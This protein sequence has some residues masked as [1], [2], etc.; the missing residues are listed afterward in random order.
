[1]L[2]VADFGVISRPIPAQRTYLLHRWNVHADLR[3]AHVP[4]SIH[5]CAASRSTDAISSEKPPSL[6]TSRA[7]A[8]VFSSDWQRGELHGYHR[9]LR[10][11][12]MPTMQIER[13]HERGRV[14][15]HIC[16]C[17]ALDIRFLR[18]APTIAPVKNLS[19][20]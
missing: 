2:S 19:F 6:I 14:A 8:T 12:Q 5:R 11:A 13:H 1:M 17:R 3:L 16:T 10:L 15:A 7:R 18:C 4:R 20:A 9:L